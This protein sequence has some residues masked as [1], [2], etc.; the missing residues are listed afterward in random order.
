[1]S[2]LELATIRRKMSYILENLALLEPVA[3]LD[4]EAFQSDIDRRDAS[5]H[6]LQTCL[7]AAIDINAHLLVNG[8]HPPP[9]DAHQS[10]IELSGKLHILPRKL[11]ELL[12][13]GAGLRNRLVHRYDELSEVRILD[14]IREAV[15][16]LPQYVEAIEA[17]L[18]KQ[19][20]DDQP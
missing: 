5:E 12:A 9:A 15:D 10:F 18:T 2:P 20:T 13:P 17:Y 6:R 14:G 7:E 11:A 1:M 16:L 19:P 3:K 8:G 4:L